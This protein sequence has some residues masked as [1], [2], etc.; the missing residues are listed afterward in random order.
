MASL[1][2][3]ERGTGPMNHKRCFNLSQLLSGGGFE[4]QPTPSTRTSGSMVPRGFPTFMPHRSLHVKSRRCISARNWLCQV[5]VLLRYFCKGNTRGTVVVFLYHAELA[6]TFPQCT[7]RKTPR[8]CVFKS[9][10][11][12]NAYISCTGVPYATRQARKRY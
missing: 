4:G 5:A 3:P 12:P 7:P 6:H 2:R 8:T 1:F 11:K 9:G 10:H